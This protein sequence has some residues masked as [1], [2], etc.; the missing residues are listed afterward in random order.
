M[1]ITCHTLF[2]FAALVEGKA[3]MPFFQRAKTWSVMRKMS[4]DMMNVVPCVL[5]VTQRAGSWKQR[6]L[7][8]LVGVR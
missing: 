6:D 4:S 7:P 8:P 1:C 5:P 2:S 3:R